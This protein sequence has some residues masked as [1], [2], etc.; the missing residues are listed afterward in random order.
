[1]KR[2]CIFATSFYKE[3]VL[4]RLW[5]E[6]PKTPFG[7]FTRSWRRDHCSLVNPYG[8]FCPYAEEDCA[9]A[10]Y[11]VADRTMREAKTSPVGLFKAI[12]KST[13]ITRSESKPLAR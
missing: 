7:A 11:Q 13:G 6:H 5:R 4:D 9:L 1:M 2:P 8:N 3:Q 12:A 10:F